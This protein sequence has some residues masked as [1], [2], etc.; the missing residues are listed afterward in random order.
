[1]LLTRTGLF[2]ARL[3]SV[4]VG[5]GAGEIAGFGVGA[6]VGA[7][8]VV[9]FGVGAG[10]GTGVAVG[11]G[12]G[13]GVGAGVTV[14]CGAGVGVRAGAG[15]GAGDEDVE[16]YSWPPI[17]GELPRLAPKKSVLTADKTIALLIIGELP[18]ILK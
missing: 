16:P 14:G 17:S 3:L 15:A 5:V 18:E 2:R 12:V 4:V 7:G 11:F 1:M 8:V 13:T 9:G 10:V 6:G